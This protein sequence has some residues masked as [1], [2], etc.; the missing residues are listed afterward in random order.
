MIDPTTGQE[1]P[2]P[3]QAPE[4]GVSTDA[5]RLA[6]LEG[7][8]ERISPVLV[9]LNASPDLVQAVLAD[10]INDEFAKAA[11]E[12]K[13]SIKEAEAATAAVATVEKDLGTK[14]FNAASPDELSKL[15]EEKISALKNEWTERDDMKTF[16]SY[17]NQF[18]SETA[19]FSKYSENISKW[20]DEHDVTDV[21][22]AYYAVKGELSEKQAKE[23]ADADA[24]ENAKNVMLSAGGGNIPSNAVVGGQPFIDSLIANR[25]NPNRL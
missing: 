5:N 3:G 23:K 18:I 20:L 25:T 14:A 1:V 17:T 10:K 6:E 12:G 24:A 15:V 2:V 21:R 4:E 13:L 7:F 8:F 11:L 19:D 16:E 9:K 22:V